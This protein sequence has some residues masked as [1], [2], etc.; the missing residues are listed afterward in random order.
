MLIKSVL[1]QEGEFSSRGC[2]NIAHLIA[3]ALKRNDPDGIKVGKMN[4]EILSLQPTK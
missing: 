4:S 1:P 2:N 3:E